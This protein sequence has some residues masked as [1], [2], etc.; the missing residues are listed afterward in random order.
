MNAEN[1]IDA[2]IGSYSGMFGTFVKDEGFNDISASASSPD[3]DSMNIV[4]IEIPENMTEEYENR[5]AFIMSKKKRLSPMGKLVEFSH[6]GSAEESYGG[7]LN[8][9]ILGKSGGFFF[10]TARKGNVLIFIQAY[11]TTGKG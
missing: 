10:Y 4:R 11:S 2:F 6:D 5:K 8:F 3:G 9:K 1:M 7:I